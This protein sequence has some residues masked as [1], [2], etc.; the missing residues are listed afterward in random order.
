M[1]AVAEEIFLEVGS[2][3][4][5]ESCSDHHHHHHPQQ[6]QDSVQT[7]EHASIFLQSGDGDEE[8]ITGDH[9]KL[10][11]VADGDGSQGL[12]ACEANGHWYPGL[13]CGVWLGTHAPLF[14]QGQVLVSNAYLRFRSLCASHPA[15][16]SALYDAVVGPDRVKSFARGL[17][18]RLTGAF[19]GFSA[20][21][22]ALVWRRVVANGYAPSA[23]AAEQALAESIPNHDQAG[24]TPTSADAQVQAMM[25]LLRE[26]SAISYNGLD[27]TVLIGNLARMRRAGLRF[28]C[29]YH[30]RDFLVLVERVLARGVQRVKA[31]ALHAIMPG[32]GIPSDISVVFDGVSIGSSTVFCTQE[33]LLPIG[34][35]FMP[36]EL[37]DVASDG[38]VL[39]D[40]PSMG[41]SHQGKHQKELVLRSLGSH[42]WG[43][44]ITLLHP[45]LAAVGG[46]GAV[47]RAGPEAC[48]KSSGAADM[49]WQ[50]IF[51]DAACHCVEWDFF[52]RQ[53][54]CGNRALSSVPAAVELQEVISV[55]MSL[56]GVGMGPVILR[57]SAEAAGLEHRR[58]KG[59]A[60]TRT[61]T[62]I[63]EAAQNL[64]DNFEAYHAALRTRYALVEEGRTSQTLKG[65]TKV[66]ARFSALDFV[67]F[68][69]LFVD[70]QSSSIVKLA[71]ASEATLTC[72]FDI[73][74]A[75]DRTLQH[76]T[77]LVIDA[78][79][80]LRFWMEGPNR[81]Q[82]SNFFKL[83][84]QFTCQN[85]KKAKI[86][87]N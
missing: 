37:W 71:L 3:E 82:T 65:L 30:S 33:T 49:I 20:S 40:L 46:D 12:V 9:D 11:P 69:L 13:N 75:L 64:I 41:G 76:L 80:R 68:L 57:S 66:S 26:C 74:T 58:T 73:M 48:H 5:S 53:N 55:L 51:P 87:Q 10:L 6:T 86:N 27:D 18:D 29:K 24:K 44:T 61:S 14:R 43:L 79:P 7:V 28:G 25:V 62:H 47:V 1:L 83:G 70:V 19:F 81:P 35:T 45:R 67:C 56:F 15:L 50:E 32:L 60:G 52:H 77:L 16:C 31:Q 85:N 4:G 38:L 36:L 22:S 63:G 2:E 8:A 72:S 21:Y 34:V 78:L 17:A 54:V 84:F 39:V 42:P 59:L 23:P